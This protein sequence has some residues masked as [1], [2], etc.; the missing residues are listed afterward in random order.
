MRSHPELYRNAQQ[1]ALRRKRTASPFVQNSIAARSTDARN[2]RN[3]R[4]SPVSGKD[5]C[6]AMEMV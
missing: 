6:A 2:A 5:A 4:T 1:P 3:R